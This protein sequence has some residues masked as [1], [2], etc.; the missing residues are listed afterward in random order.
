MVLWPRTVYASTSVRHSVRRG[1]AD[2]KSRGRDASR[3]AGSPRRRDHRRRRHAADGTSAST[4]F[5]LDA[6]YELSRAQ[7][8]TEAPRPPRAAAAG[9]LRRSRPATLARRPFPILVPGWSKPFD[10]PAHPS[11][12]CQD[13]VLS[14]QPWQSPAYHARHSRL[15]ASHQIGHKPENS[16]FVISAP[17]HRR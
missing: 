7:R 2:R 4:L 15:P 3:P 1:D 11:S 10:R 12:P 16:G 6:D 13:R 14:R 8:A 17:P 5:D 9:R